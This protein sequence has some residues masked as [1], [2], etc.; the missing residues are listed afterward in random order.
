[1]LTLKDIKV[2]G[3]WNSEAQSEHTKLNVYVV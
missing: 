1:M 3:K 2:L